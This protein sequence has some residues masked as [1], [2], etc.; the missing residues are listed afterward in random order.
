MEG[1]IQF[2]QRKW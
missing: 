1:L 2:V